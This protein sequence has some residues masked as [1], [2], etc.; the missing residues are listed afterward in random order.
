MAE[1]IGI[2]EDIIFRNEDNGFSVIEV[3]EEGTNHL[4]TAVGGFPFISQGERI[5]LEGEWTTHPDYGR[6]LKMLNYSSAAPSTIEGL[7]NYLAS[8]LIKGVGEATARK[9]VQLFGLDVLDIIQFNPQRL[10]EVD[11]IGQRRAEMIASSFSEQKEIREV[12][13]FLQSYGITTAY[14]LKIYKM[15]GGN[16]VN[17]VRENPY[18]LAEDITG[19]GFKTA[20]RI[21]GSLGVDMDS[22]YRAA[23]GIRY[24]LSEAAA[25][26]H[27]FLPK[28]VLLEKA[29]KLLA[30]DNLIIENS[31]TNLALTHSIVM[32]LTEEY[33]AVYRAG[34]YQAEAGA[35]RMLRDL[36]VGNTIKQYNNI[37]ENIKRFEEK[38][39]ICLA[40]QQREAVCSAMQHGVLIITGG[41]G[42]GKTTAINCIIDLM[43]QKGLKVEL[44]A[45]TGRAAKRLA[46]T[47]GR[48]ART[49]HRL[50]EYGFGDEHEYAFQ[51]NEDNPVKADAV[52]IDEMSMVDI[53]LIFHMLKA[54]AQ[55]TR[56]IMVGDV[57]QLPAV[58]PGNVLRD[59][60]QSEV[61]PV[62]QLTEIFRQAQESMIIVNA[63]RI[64]RGE[65]P[66]LNVTDKDFFFD[67]R[68]SL[69]DVLKTLIDLVVRRLPGFGDY[70][71]LQDIQILAPMRKGTIGVNNLNTELQ[72][73]LNPPAYNKKEKAY[74]QVVFRQGDKVM[75]I[76]N[77]YRL[78]WT[79]HGQNGETYEGEG[80]FNG[81][82][83]FIQD[84]DTEEQ[85]LTVLFDDDK[86]VVY[87]FSQLDELELSYAI[88]IHKSQG[89]EFPVVIIPLVS[90][91]PMLMTRN[92][93]YTG[94]T[95]A[96]KLV[97]LVGREK[98][99]RLM[100][101]NNRIARR[102]SGLDYR[103][104]QAFGMALL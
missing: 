27:T 23:A 11:G 7:T 54:I 4:V 104:K 97:V 20:D 51:R 73:A 61:I 80:V 85:T 9:L 17:V 58:G 78:Q 70:H 21:A 100:V 15:Y 63:H 40:E 5:R 91:P 67:K 12:M 29:S 79:R 2:V 26:G 62:I 101:R 44:A 48:E 22:P 96:K 19:I 35:S 32:E 60:I 25:E 71:S 98:T 82:L 102:Y 94:V 84:I 69:D 90:G 14:A 28:E 24:I 72:K 52:I 38:N 55:G 31:L 41:P 76:K 49:I 3:R 64:N 1:V 65:N 13:I 8:G 6:Q 68:E 56:L 33:T 30:I 59:M 46:E 86:T 95:R 87:D 39:H 43:E 103:L 34:L 75:Q 18:R 45:P 92:L 88:S 57:D 47:T 99:I 42:T 93:L 53:L 83:G 37:E 36:A 81:D 74:G 50:L 10:T 77:N 66:F 89:C 16:T